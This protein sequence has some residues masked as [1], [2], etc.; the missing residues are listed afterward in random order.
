MKH[1]LDRYELQQN[2]EIDLAIFNL[3][4]QKV[5]QVVNGIKSKGMHT[6]KVDFQRYGLASVT[7]F[8]R[9]QSR[10]QIMTRP[11]CFSK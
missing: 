9:I 7:Y 4:G 3:L 6:V 10:E 2:E 1:W 11:V 5:I 8:V